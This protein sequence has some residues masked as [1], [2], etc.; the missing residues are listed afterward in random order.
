MT[1]NWHDQAKPCDSMDPDT[2]FPARGDRETLEVALAACRRCSVT[3]E[4]LA[5]AINTREKSGI[6]GGTTGLERREMIS[7]EVAS[8]R[9]VRP[10]S[11]HGSRSRYNGGCRCDL[12]RMA[13]AA[14][15]RGARFTPRPGDAPVNLA[16]IED[17]P[18]SETWFAAATQDPKGQFD[19]DANT[20]VW[21][22][23]MHRGRR[24][25]AA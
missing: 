3:A 21:V 22:D 23:Q 6:W 10:P 8:G 7:A 9:V 13:N 1:E 5:H 24:D 15:N 12:C 19:R 18:L 4:C 20:R 2:F 16:P 14:Y 17:L 11:E 25:G